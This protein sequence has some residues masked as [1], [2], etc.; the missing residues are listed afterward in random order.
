MNII[1]ALEQDRELPR[2]VEHHGGMWIAL[3]G[4]PSSLIIKSALP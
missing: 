1:R 3:L 2:E 4:V